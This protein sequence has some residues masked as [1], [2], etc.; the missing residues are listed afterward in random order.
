METRRVD[1]FEEGVGE[2]EGT[3]QQGWS[4][5]PNQFVGGGLWEQEG[6]THAHGWGV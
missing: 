6:L 1:S 3:L 5:V 2:G 4:Q